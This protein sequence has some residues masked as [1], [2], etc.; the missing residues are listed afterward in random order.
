MSNIF[1]NKGIREQYFS[2]NYELIWNDRIGFAKVAI[3]AKVVKHIHHTT[4]RPYL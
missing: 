4:A 2:D 3:Q 1:Q